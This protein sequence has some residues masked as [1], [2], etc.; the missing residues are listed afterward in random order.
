MK[1]STLITLTVLTT[2]GLTAIGFVNWTSS[3]KIQEAAP[4]NT[5][6]SVNSE[7]E[8][9]TSGD[10]VI[11]LNF[12]LGPKLGTTITKEKLHQATS[13]VDVLPAET[14]WPSYP[15]QSMIVTVFHGSTETREIGKHLDLSAS[16][17]QLLRTLDYS[18]CFQFKAPCI[19]K[20]KDTG[21]PENY[22]LNYEF[23]V[24]PE[25]ETQYSEGKDALIAYLKENSAAQTLNVKQ[26]R[27]DWG[28]V[29]FTISKSG[30][31]TNVYLASTS[32]YQSLD[33]V[34]IK[35]I[36]ALPGSWKPASNSKGE[37]VDQELAFSFGRRGC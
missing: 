23:T 14:D 12:I 3:E 5:T 11:E 7:S 9:V 16:Q 8:Q 36:N 20:H 26:D 13:V 27:L 34:M 37:Y 18:D 29:N 35:L 6:A 24:T 33:E 25:N 22:E 19:G 30:T 10:P 17:Q 32:G 1:K 4:Y 28:K 15:I 21:E 31:L 2:L